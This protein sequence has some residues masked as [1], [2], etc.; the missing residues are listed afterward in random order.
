MSEKNPEAWGVTILHVDYEQ[1]IPQPLIN[2]VAVF[3]KEDAEK[4]FRYCPSLG[5]VYTINE[6]TGR[7]GIC[8]SVMEAEHWYK[9]VP[10]E[11]NFDKANS[12]YTKRI[13]NMHARM[14]NIYNRLVKSN[15]E[16]RSFATQTDNFIRMLLK[17]NRVTK[18]ELAKYFKAK[19]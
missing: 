9:N 12:T 15:K 14:T 5:F 6:D 2:A 17:E 8:Y 3:S 10:V 11:G 18:E 13:N 19:K 16:K 7:V 1:I 4:A